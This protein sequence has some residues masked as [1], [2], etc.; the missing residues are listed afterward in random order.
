MSKKKKGMKEKK[1]E[2]YKE[3]YSYYLID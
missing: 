2:S 3:C 1:V